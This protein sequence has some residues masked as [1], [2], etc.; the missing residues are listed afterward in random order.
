MFDVWPNVAAAGSYGSCLI[1]VINC[2]VQ[3][4]AYIYICL[5]IRVY[6]SAIYA[7]VRLEEFVVLQR[8][9]C[10]LLDWST[11]RLTPFSASLL[12]PKFCFGW[13]SL[14]FDF[15]FGLSNYY[16]YI[17]CC[18]SSRTAHFSFSNLCFVPKYFGHDRWIFGEVLINV[19]KSNEEI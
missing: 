9:G 13:S 2:R 15:Y 4:A 16:Y 14:A 17:S 7:T 6:M 10:K 12:L 18:C 19:S 5:C 8:A 11:V 3:H 1:A